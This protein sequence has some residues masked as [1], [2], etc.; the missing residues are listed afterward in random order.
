MAR[1]AC[2][3]GGESI[4]GQPV[5]ILVWIV[6]LAELLFL[7]TYIAH[8]RRPSIKI[9]AAFLSGTYRI[10][11]QLRAAAEAS[12]SPT[13]EER[14]RIRRRDEALMDDILL[15][16]EDI[17][18]KLSG[19]WE[20]TNGILM[21]AVAALYAEALLSAVTVPLVA[22]IA[23]VVAFALIFAWLM[24]QFGDEKKR[25]KLLEKAEKVQRIAGEYKSMV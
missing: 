2:Q 16:R 11:T 20:T 14:E 6:A 19:V 7:A 10:S 25:R 3:E 4:P 8:A 23:A 13:Q 12:D 22:I 17:R 9:A 15:G 1:C 21:A 18:A 24:S 5:M